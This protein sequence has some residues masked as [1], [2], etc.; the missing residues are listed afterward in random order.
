M[1]QQPQQPQQQVVNVEEHRQQRNKVI[2]AGCEFNVPDRYEIT[3]RIGLGAYGIVVSAI[4]KTTGSKVAIKKIANV[5]ESSREY[6]KRILR[7]IASLKHLSGHSNIIEL[8]EIIQPEDYDSFNDVY[9]VCNYMDSTIKD[10]LKNKQVAKDITDDHIKWFVYQLLRGLK[11]MHSAG[12]VHRDIKPSNILIDHDMELRLCDLGLSREYSIKEEMEMTT[13]VSTRWYRAPELLLRYSRSGPAIDIWSAGCIF[14]ELLS[15]KKKVLFP[16]NHYI[17]QLEIILDL[18]GTPQLEEE[19]AMVKGSPEAK[20]W[21]KTLRKRPRKSLHSLFP[22]ANPLAL[23]LLDKMLQLDP[24]KRITATQA[25][26]HEYFA[27]LYDPEEEEETIAE[28][29]NFCIPNM[30]EI[31]QQMFNEIVCTGAC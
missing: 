2:I 17:Q 16:G 28:A 22:T 10:M 7:E 31:K 19:Y 6:Q 15:P 9:I 12:V 1:H 14:A 5:F 11:Y 26:Q 30:R 29:F 13:Y 20:R 18:V 4:D 23:D 21:L 24:E 3:Q 8:I 27:D 25:L